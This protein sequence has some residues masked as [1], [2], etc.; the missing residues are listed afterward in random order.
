[1]SAADRSQDCFAIRAVRKSNGS[2]CYYTA[3]G[4][5]EDAF[6]SPGS[7]AL[8]FDSLG[9]ASLVKATLEGPCLTGVDRLQVVTLV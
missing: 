8:I 9:E 7:R 1:M 3:S 2:F 4:D 6:H 5:F